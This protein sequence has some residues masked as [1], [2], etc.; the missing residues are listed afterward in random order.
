MKKA[1][2]I[3][4][5]VLLIDQISKIYIKTHFALDEYIAIFGADWAKIYFTENKGA[6]WGFQLNNIFTF[7]SEKQAKIILTLF[8]VV[9]IS[10]IGYW[11][12]T[13]IKKQATSIFIVAVSLI[14]A[15]AIGN[16][17]DSVFYG[18][19]FNESTGNNVAIFLSES[20][21]YAS[22][23]HGKVVDMFYFPMW[24]GILPSWIPFKGGEAF[25]FFNAIF[26]IADAAISCG[27]GLLIFFNKR[28]FPD[29]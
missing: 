12:Y 14:F 20:G 23:F 3:I 27:V 1:G 19:L 16:I 4:I 26:N 18:V 8:R 2:I 11:L 21:G 10:G 25:T 24:R 17:I 15:G 6:A 9:A 7:L 22:F 29:G 5:L 13:T 28:A